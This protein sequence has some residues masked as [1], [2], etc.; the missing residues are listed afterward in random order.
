MKKLLIGLTLLA[1]MSSFAAKK[2][3]VRENC[4]IYKN[5][6]SSGFYVPLNLALAD[7][8]FEVVDDINEASFE[9]TYDHKDRSKVKST[10]FSDET[11]SFQTYD[12]KL[13]DLIN[14]SEVRHA[15]GRLLRLIPKTLQR[16]EI[17]YKTWHRADPHRSFE[18]REN[19]VEAVMG[20]IKKLP[21]CKL[22]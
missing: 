14:R 9:W 20:A 21:S 22:K 8:G 12:L 13:K 15:N 6:S 16:N 10:W 3:L 1:S 11:Y 5:Y 7:K 2:E 19:V 18:I 4:N 17:T